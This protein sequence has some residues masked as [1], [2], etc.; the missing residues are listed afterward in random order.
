[1][2]SGLRI[3]PRAGRSRTSA[4]RGSSRP[5]IRVKHGDWLALN[6]GRPENRRMWSISSS[7][8][9]PRRSR[10]VRNLDG[11]ACPGRR[12]PALVNHDPPTR[13][14]H[15]ITWSVWVTFTSGRGD[16]RV[17][18]VW[19]VNL[20]Y[21]C[22]TL[23]WIRAERQ[24]SAGRVSCGGH[25]WWRCS[26]R[27][28]PLAEDRSLIGYWMFSGD[29]NDASRRASL[30]DGGLRRRLSGTL[31]SGRVHAMEVGQSVSYDRARRPA[32]STRH[33]S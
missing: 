1:M 21:S 23:R 29:A 10:E 16:P 7:R 17:H 2:T 24:V 33:H 8:P 5:P 9:A 25:C 18:H 14:S 27:G 32:G 20:E 31:P 3:G 13:S 4:H 12:S 28:C 6:R 15:S 11:T 19:R 26:S 22:Q 30:V